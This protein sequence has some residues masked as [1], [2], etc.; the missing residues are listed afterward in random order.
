QRAQDTAL[1]RTVIDL[2]SALGLRV[3]AEGVETAL[4]AQLLRALGCNSAQGYYFA[5]PTAPADLDELVRTWQ[6]R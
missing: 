1:V 4:Q 5:R 3:T 6:A 2:A